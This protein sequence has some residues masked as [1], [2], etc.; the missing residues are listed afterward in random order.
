MRLPTRLVPRPQLRPYGLVLGGDL[1]GKVVVNLQDPSETP[2]SYVT[3]VKE[4]QGMLFLGTIGEDSIK[5]IPV[6]VPEDEDHGER[7]A[8]LATSRGSLTI[9]RHSSV[10]QR[11]TVHSDLILIGRSPRT[12]AVLGP[13]RTG[14]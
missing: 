13:I 12:A 5:R 1:D 14:K 4:H 10:R 11:V 6:P 7:V 2:A 3:G 8:R 9:A